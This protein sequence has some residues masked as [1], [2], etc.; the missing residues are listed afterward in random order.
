MELERRRHYVVLFPTQVDPN[1]TRLYHGLLR[2]QDARVFGVHPCA[3]HFDFSIFQH[4]RTW[5]RKNNVS[6]SLKMAFSLRMAVYMPQAHAPD[7]DVS[8]MQLRSMSIA[9]DKL[10]K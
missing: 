1:Y 8:F 10:N 5:L 9:Y 3:E 2:F 6:R 7:N 4:L